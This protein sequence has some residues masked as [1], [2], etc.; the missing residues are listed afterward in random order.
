MERLYHQLPSFKE[1][2][3]V[4]SGVNLKP[5]KKIDSVA[6]RYF[7]PLIVRRQAKQ[8]NCICQKSLEL[9]LETAQKV[10]RNRTERTV[11]G[12][13]AA[14]SCTQGKNFSKN[15]KKVSQD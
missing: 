12:T 9:P 1:F 8:A 3:L 6:H 14:P 13:N 2:T 11:P 5:L 10:H 4:F 15:I 7:F